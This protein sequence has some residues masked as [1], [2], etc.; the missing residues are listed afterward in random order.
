MEKEAKVLT[1]VLEKGIEHTLTTFKMVKTGLV[2][3]ENGLYKI[4]EPIYGHALR[5]TR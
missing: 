3:K 5:R 4:A 1:S 2:E